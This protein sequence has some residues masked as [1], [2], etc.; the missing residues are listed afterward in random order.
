MPLKRIEFWIEIFYSKV[1]DNLSFEIIVAN[2]AVVKL[3]VS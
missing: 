1:S 3:V 2:K